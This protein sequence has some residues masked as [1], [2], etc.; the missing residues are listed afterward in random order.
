[1]VNEH[2]AMRLWGYE[3]MSPAPKSGIPKPRQVAVDPTW[4]DVASDFEGRRRWP[5]KQVFEILESQLLEQPVPWNQGGN[6]KIDEKCVF[7][8]LFCSCYNVDGVY[9][10]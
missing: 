5:F 6:V 3:A 7:T 2:V 9:Y 1:M 8:F 4:D 10:I